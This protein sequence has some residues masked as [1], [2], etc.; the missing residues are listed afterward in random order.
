MLLL[1]IRKLE[2]V[3]TLI[4]SFEL[5]L[6]SSDDATSRKGEK[7]GYYASFYINRF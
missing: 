6:F 5:I 2:L 1:I 4:I 7:L 3:L